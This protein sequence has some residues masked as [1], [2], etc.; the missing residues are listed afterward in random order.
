MFKR[1]YRLAFLRFKRNDPRYATSL[2]NA[3]LISRLG[4]K[5]GQA[6]RRYAKA[7]KLWSQV[8][9]RIPELQI[10]PRA[11]SSLFHLRMEAR[12]WD[13]YRAN[14]DARLAGFARES[15]ACLEAIAKGEAPPHRLYTCWRGEQPSVFDDSR[16]FLAAALLIAAVKDE[17]AE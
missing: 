15:E 11:R 5:E 17:N 4:G 2:A 10:K 8:P 6:A 13:T 16:K 9:D 1:A 7:I 14:M 3:A 12:H